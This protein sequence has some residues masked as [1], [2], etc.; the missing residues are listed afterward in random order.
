MAGLLQGQ[1]QMTDL[2]STPAVRWLHLTDIH[3]GRNVESQQT[4]LRSL[5][6]AV[7]EFAENKSFD[8][9][10]LTGD[11]ANSGTRDEY[12]R[13][14]SELIVPLR[15]HPLFRSAV[16]IAAPGNHDLDCS[17]E[18]PPVWKDIGLSRQEK[19]FHLGADGRRTR[20]SRAKAFAE[21]SSFAARTGIRT[22][23][24]TLEPA[25]ISSFTKDTR[26]IHFIS[27]VTAYFSDKE[28]SDRQ[29]SPAPLHPLRSLMQSVRQEEEIV[30][31]GH[32]PPDW[33]TRES[34]QQLH[35]LL[36]E[37][38]ALYLHGHE[39]RITIRFGARGLAVLGFGAAY[40]AA[41][42]AA[43]NVQYKNSFAICE[44]TSKLHVS[45]VSW[46]AAYGQWRPDSSLPGD[47]IDRSTQLVGGYQFELPR[48]RLAE[49]TKAFSSLAGAIR[50]ELRI[51]K[52]LW[53]VE[54]DSARWV[55]LLSTIGTF[56]SA[57]DNYNLPTQSLPVGHVEFR[58]KDDRLKYLIYAVSGVGDIL[59]FEQLQSINTELD[60]QDYDAC[61][62]ATLGEL[63]PEAKTL[64]A[65]LS[66]KK[67]IIVLERAE[68]IRR[69]LRNVPHG[70]DR[71]LLRAADANRYEGTLIIT[72]TSFSLMLRDRNDR[73]SFHVVDEN[74][75][76]APE[77]SP[78][79]QSI[80]ADVA[81]IRA[82]RYDFSA[83]EIPVNLDSSI[84]GAFDRA[85]Y[86]A[87]TY[88]YFDD[89]KYAP[90][91]ALGF[92]FRKTSLSELYV[93]A[94]ADV[95]APS[96][97]AS[98]LNRALTEFVDSLNLPKAQQDQLESQLKS[99]YGMGR[100]A[101]VGGARKFYQ[102]YNNVVVL[103]DPG[104]GK[105][106]FVQH[107]ILAYCD[108]NGDG[109]SGWYKQHLPIYVSLSEASRLSDANTT[110]LDICAVVSSR[111]GIDLSRAVIDDALAEGRAAFFFDGLDEV[112]FLD[113]RIALVSEISALVSA[114]AYRGNRFVIASRPAAIQP[115]DMPDGLTHLQL[116]GLTES[117]I[118]V[119]ATR[120]FTSRIGE[121]EIES[122]RTEEEELVER[123]L[124]DVRTIPGIARIARNPL[125]LTLLVLIYANAGAL[126]AR[127]H[128]IYT[129]AIK[130]LVSVRGRQTREQQISEADLRTR[131]G[132]IALSVFSRKIAELPRRAEVL[133]ILA[134]MIGR[135]GSSRGRNGADAADAFV[136]EVAEA[137]GL[138]AIHTM[139]GPKADD[140]I[141]FMH[142][143][144]LEYYAAAGLLTQSY[145]TEVPPLGG[146]PRWTDVIT[147]LFGMLSDQGDVSPLLSAI[148]ADGTPEGAISKHRLILAM[149][150]AAECDVPPESS[151]EL[152]AAAIYETVSN[153]AGRYSAEL[154][155]EIAKRL[156]DLAQSA[157]WILE[158]TLNQGLRSS[159]AIA[160]A[161]FADLMGQIDED[162]SLTTSIVS[163]F[164]SCLEHENPVTRA[165]A[166][167]SIGQRQELR[168]ELALQI[169]KQ[170]MS[171]SIVEKHAALKAVAVVPAFAKSL[172]VE[173]HNLLDD[174]N[175]LI[176]AA[177]AQCSLPELLHGGV[178][179]KN[180][181]RLQK[182]LLKLN[183][184][185]NEDTGLTLRGLTLDREVVR[186]LASSS[187]P[188][189][190]E[191]AI[192]YLWLVKDDNQFVY[193]LLMQRL[194]ASSEPRHQSAC[195]DAL[196]ECPAA[197]DLITIA[198]T[199]LICG[200]TLAG[201]R[202]VRIAAARLL[203]E[204]PDD[205]QVVR[206]LQTL[207]DVSQ[208]TPSRAEEL[209]EAAKSISKHAYR[210]PRIRV[211][212]LTALLDKLPKRAQD[213][214]GDESNQRH[215][216]ALL[217]V[218]ESIGG[219]AEDASAWRLK[220]LADDF[221]T[222]LAI[223]SMAMRVFGGI[224]QPETRSISIFISL[225]RKDDVRLNEAVYAA[226]A[227][228]IAQCR[229]RVE[230]VRLVYAD[231]S[232]L[233][234]ALT[235]AWT[236]EIASSRDSI[237]PS[238]LKHIRNS[239]I[240][241]TALIVAYEEFARAN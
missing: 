28:V 190:C 167:F 22:V 226:T 104:S 154:R 186:S 231:L 129:Q 120:V 88:A 158:Q 149:D 9:V 188:Y 73:T 146:N 240:E 95:D 141:T 11:L 198:D 196:R 16:L 140:L 143:S 155:F 165:A 181:P 30:V 91:A 151:Q 54:N 147:L 117:E 193:E 79:V 206:T 156:S 78:L 219:V 169:I 199:D 160:A 162:V 86:L 122:L 139:D 89:V 12:D 175:A 103:G 98:Q 51:Q 81:S 85:K 136:Q 222:P 228:F 87:T 230:Y 137:T 37:H 214:F 5:L 64:A 119:L 84:T 118:K 145:L 7:E 241:I 224:V 35:S 237:S 205:E 66:S 183:Q 25:A 177:A 239:V 24:P 33:F 134:P 170:S 121:S 168:S 38:N 110:L 67:S 92:K 39:H 36:V 99:Q 100:S 10:L 13:L 132:A 70:L 3:M 40:Q 220:G 45:V 97:G 109:A 29:R 178:D 107:E 96:K 229:R 41:N 15:N 116:K 72:E 21:Y 192:R 106:C 207:F 238:P 203:G 159:D 150:C 153:G 218:C 75:D 211:S 124:E 34:E 138:L 62:V 112:G 59:S 58:I 111:R 55:K 217:S 184:G 221:R 202:N 102:R 163:A 128:L 48:T 227:S 1:L 31:L 172:S 56:R 194:R 71:A 173:I 114:H 27:S 182:V 216:I 44:M 46:D 164:G 43:P 195:L 152:L 19:F 76:V 83:A 123:L 23:D 52:C 115:V 69:A 17:V 144:F 63:S 49:R 74:G 108:S 50:S 90:L 212:S 61:I 157:Y 200:L 6:N 213:G 18:Y 126:S 60:R 142:Y 215:I 53:L 235:L 101:E 187:D 133:S 197:I 82:L 105:T 236:R 127:R 180:K 161:A 113:K 8:L 209:S 94:S 210:N 57:S 26:T 185:A 42:D 208:R 2:N 14:E 68:L 4:A 131:L 77:A 204:M 32:H 176:A 166:M 191:L 174:P 232:A 171:G 93:G 65:Q 135:A 189:E 179:N 233:R 130:T 20:G 234:T 148:L 125:L 47:F 225:L 80:K 223:R 201:N